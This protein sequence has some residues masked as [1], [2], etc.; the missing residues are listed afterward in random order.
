MYKLTANNQTSEH[1]TIK[2]AYKAKKQ[3]RKAGY[4]GNITMIDKYNCL[5]IWAKRKEKTT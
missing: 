2:Q 4:T 5:T 3:L 1:A